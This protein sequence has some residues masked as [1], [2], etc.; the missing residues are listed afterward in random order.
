MMAIYRKA[1]P[2]VPV[3]L[4]LLVGLCFG[5]EAAGEAAKDEGFLR[6]LLYE[7]TMRIINFAILAGLL[8]YLLAEKVKTFFAG[9]REEIASTIDEVDKAKAEAEGRYAEYE[10]K[11][12]GLEAE[13]AHIKELVSGEVENEHNRIMAESKEAAENVIAAARLSAEQEIAK[14]RK[15][16]KDQVVD[17]AAEMAA[18]MVSKSMDSKDQSRILDEYLEKVG[19]QK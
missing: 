4:I 13:I 17:L 9:R 10:A 16:L 15:A 5:S 19:S 3:L 18:G 7:N 12:K 1:L 6:S 14:A 11:I 8:W 2:L